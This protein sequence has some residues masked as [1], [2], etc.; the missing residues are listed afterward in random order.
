[1]RARRP[2]R[3]RPRVAQG[4]AY[5]DEERFP[6]KM[7]PAIAFAILPV[8][9]LIIGAGVIAG[10]MLLA[11]HQWVAG[12]IALALGWPLAFVLGRLV[13]QLSRRWIVLVPA[14]VVIADPLTLTDP[15]LFVRERVQGIGPAD[16][17]RRHPPTPSTSG[18]ARR[19]ARARCSSPTRPT[20]CA[21]SAVRACTSG[22]GS[23][24]DADGAGAVCSSVPASAACPSGATD[25]LGQTA[26]P[27][28]S[29]RSPS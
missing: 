23:S 16:P 13:H 15:V 29:T 4:A 6:L 25:A 1:M 22:P 17:G 3:L 10:P 11:A 5:G 14:G 7:P 9:I 12:A 26:V 8:A 20:S 28:P 2:W 18:S 19:S 21:G 24:R 27:A